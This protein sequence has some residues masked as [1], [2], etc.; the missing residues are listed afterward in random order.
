MTHVVP[1]PLRREKSGERLDIVVEDGLR[2]RIRGHERMGEER[3]TRHPHANHASQ[4]MQGL[5]MWKRV[6]ARSIVRQQQAPVRG[7]GRLLGS[8]SEPGYRSPRSILKSCR[9]AASGRMAQRTK[10]AVRTLLRLG[11]RTIARCGCPS[12][13]VSPPSTLTPCG[14][15]APSASSSSRPP[16]QRAANTPAS[17]DR[18]PI[19]RSA[20]P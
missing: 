9:K 4:S 18:E 13:A 16:H 3:T 12:R 20:P 17:K 5:P 10:A 2:G 11:V 15:S 14:G 8:S 7:L 6:P 19:T 1:R